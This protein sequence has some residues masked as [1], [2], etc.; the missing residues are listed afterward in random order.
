MNDALSDD[1]AG[2][3]FVDQREVKRFDFGKRRPEEIP[4]K[5]PGHHVEFVEVRVVARNEEIRPHDALHTERLVKGF[6]IAADTL[7]ERFGQVRGEF[8]PLP[9]FVFSENESTSPP[10]K[11]SSQGESS[12]FPRRRY[13]AQLMSRLRSK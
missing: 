8:A 13:A 1:G 3:R 12:T 2:E 10:E 6:G 5:R 11:T 7:R 9:L 4:R